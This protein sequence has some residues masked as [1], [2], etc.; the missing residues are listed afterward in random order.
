M[1]YS[2]KGQSTGAKITRPLLN[3][4]HHLKFVI[5]TLTQEKKKKEKESFIPF[6]PQSQ[7]RAFLLL[8]HQRLMSLCTYQNSPLWQM[9]I[10]YCNSSI[11][12]LTKKDE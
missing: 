6:H 2:L 1:K 3:S 9:N 12:N 11:W 5:G 8:S 10:F 4:N 7:F